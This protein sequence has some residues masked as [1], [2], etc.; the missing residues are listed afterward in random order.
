MSWHSAEDPIPGDHFSCDAIRTL[1][2]PRSR[3]LGSFAVRRA[4]PFPLLQ[5]QDTIAPF[6]P[7]S[8]GPDRRWTR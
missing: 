5:L 6:L 7:R 3:D 8:G 4:L 2:V 1:I